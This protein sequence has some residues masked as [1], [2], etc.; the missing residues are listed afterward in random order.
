MN[1]ALWRDE[2]SPWTY[3]NTG[4]RLRVFGVNAATTVS[5]LTTPG[6]MAQRA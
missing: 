5:F 2:D 6:W 1:P 3:A 4:T